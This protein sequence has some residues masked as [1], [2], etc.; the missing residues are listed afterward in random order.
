[1]LWLINSPLTGEMKGKSV[2]D[3]PANTTTLPTSSWLF[4][5]L[6][7]GIESKFKCFCETRALCRL[8]AHAYQI[9]TSSTAPR[10]AALPL[11]YIPCQ[12]GL[13][14]PVWEYQPIKMHH[15]PIK[16]GSNCRATPHVTAFKANW[17][18]DSHFRL[19]FLRSHFVYLLSFLMQITVA[20]AD[21]D[22]QVQH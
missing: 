13:S 11:F 15:V 9:N 4:C 2:H 5:P 19:R 1:M 12:T 21:D 3:F 10:R 7:N 16:E 6:Q 22:L 18:P 20:P 17:S 14:C 8:L